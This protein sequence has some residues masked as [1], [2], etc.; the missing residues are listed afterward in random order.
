M[1]LSA[2]LVG[3]LAASDTSVLV[4]TYSTFCAPKAKQVVC[5]TVIDLRDDSGR[6]FTGIR[7]CNL[8]EKTCKIT[9]VDK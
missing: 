9:G 6:V 4:K 1:L 2:F 8:T 3:I 5:T 7:R